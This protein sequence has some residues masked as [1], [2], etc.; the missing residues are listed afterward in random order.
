VTECVRFLDFPAADLDGGRET[1]A[2]VLGIPHGVAYA[3]G[4]EQRDLAGA[5]AAVR[6]GVDQLVDLTDIRLDSWPADECPLC[7]DGIPINVAFARGADYLAAGGHW[8]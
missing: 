5:P 6:A 8:P 1:L 7:R 3:L 2:A 4:D